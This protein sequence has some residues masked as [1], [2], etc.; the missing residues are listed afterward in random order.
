M[1][2]RPLR[3]L[4]LGLNSYFASVEQQEQPHLRGKPVAVAPVGTPSGTIIAASYEAKAFGVR[5]GHRVREALALCPG[6]ILTPARHELYVTYH[7]AIVAEVWR[8][9]PGD[10][11]LL[12]RRGRVPAAR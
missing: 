4:Y 9:I 2:D 10:A 8:H 7:E 3:W 6:L 1:T 5:T 11:G 12:D